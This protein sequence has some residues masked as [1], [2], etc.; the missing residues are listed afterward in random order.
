MITKENLKLFYYLHKSIKNTENELIPSKYIDGG[1][2]YLED[3]RKDFYILYNTFEEDKEYSMLE[4]LNSI[5]N[6]MYT[7]DTSLLTP[8][9]FKYFT[10][11]YDTWSMKINDDW[12]MENIYTWENN[13]IWILM[14][15]EFY[16]KCDY[17]K[18]EFK[19]IDDIIDYMFL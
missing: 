12:I 7:Y 3:I 9:D 13:T 17:C 2:L 6:D 10:N 11:T 1:W 4:R 15:S 18:I 19:N 8:E 5:A 14:T 16:K